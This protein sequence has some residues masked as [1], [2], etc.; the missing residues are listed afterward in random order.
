MHFVWRCQLHGSPDT[1]LCPISMA[2]ESPGG[3]FIA[4]FDEMLPL[5][6]SPGIM[7]VPPPVGNPEPPP[8][9]PPALDPPPLKGLL[10][11]PR[12]M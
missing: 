8:D 2:Q 3:G 11:D 12:D 6:R 5:E 7:L 1:G 10:R 4:S 9:P